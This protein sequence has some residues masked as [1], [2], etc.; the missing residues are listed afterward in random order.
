MITIIVEITL[1]LSERNCFVMFLP[2]TILPTK[3]EI[4]IYR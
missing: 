1:V 2:A 4:W 3:S